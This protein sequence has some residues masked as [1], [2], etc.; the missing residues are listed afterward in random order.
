MTY[1]DLKTKA[2]AIR[3]AYAAGSITPEMV[4]GLFADLADYVHT[5]ELTPGVKKVQ[6]AELD[7]MVQTTAG[8]LQMAKNPN[9]YTVMSGDYVVGEMVFIGDTMNHGATQVLTTNL[10]LQADGTFGSDHTHTDIYTYHRTWVVRAAGNLTEVGK[11]SP[12]VAATY[13]P[14]AA[15]AVTN[16]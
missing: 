2:E 14:A 3:A 7:A 6:L 9:R 16:E 11:W 4:G 5:L 13:N 12:W 15:T 1:D 10:L 8:A